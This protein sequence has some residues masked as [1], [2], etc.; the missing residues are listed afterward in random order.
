MTKILRF[1][2]NYFF[3][4]RK[5]PNTLSTLSF[6]ADSQIE[7]DEKSQKLGGVNGFWRKSK[8]ENRKTVQKHRKSPR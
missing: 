6:K 3:Q 5:V 8:L 1:F 4:K 2:E 7:L